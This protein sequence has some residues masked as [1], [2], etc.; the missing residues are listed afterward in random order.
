MFGEI[1]G[2]NH[3][4][5]KTFRFF[6]RGKG[7]EKIQKKTPKEKGEKGILKIEVNTRF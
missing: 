1:L 2:K 6:V 4:K 7:P 3:Q 5:K